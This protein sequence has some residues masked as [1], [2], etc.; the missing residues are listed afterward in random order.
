[1][2]GRSTSSIAIADISDLSAPIATM[3]WKVIPNA[4]CPKHMAAFGAL[5]YQAHARSA[6][7]HTIGTL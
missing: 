4:S 3:F 7:I 1:M 5:P 2:A 6:N